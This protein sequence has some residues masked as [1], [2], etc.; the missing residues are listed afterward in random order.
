MLQIFVI[1]AAIV[2]MLAQ[3]LPPIPCMQSEDGLID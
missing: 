1:L 3:A 2:A